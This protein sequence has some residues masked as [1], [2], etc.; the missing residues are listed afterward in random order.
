MPVCA[1]ARVDMES[2]LD[3]VSGGLIG[4]FKGMKSQAAAI[5]KVAAKHPYIAL[6]MIIIGIIA[7]GAKLVKQ[8]MELRKEFG[9]SVGETVKLQGAM[10]GASAELYLLGVSAEEVKATAGALID[11]FGRPDGVIHND[12]SKVL[13]FTT[14]K[15]K[16]TCERKFTIN[17]EGIISGFNSRNCF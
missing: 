14:Q 5:N 10:M 2:Q 17:S 12:D 9:L 16:I 6:A 7:I 4:K 8:T 3:D 15:Y 11:E 1:K 13:V